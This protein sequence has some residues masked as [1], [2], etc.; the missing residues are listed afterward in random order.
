MKVASLLK[1]PTAVSGAL[2]DRYEYDAFGQPYSGDLSSAMNLGYTGKPYDTATG[3]Y[4]YGYRDY[5]PQMARFTTLDPIRDGNNWFA[6][7]NNDPVNWVDLWGLCADDVGITIWGTRTSIGQIPG[8]YGYV[9]QDDMWASIPLGLDTI[10]KQGCKVTGASQIISSI[11]GFS[12]S[13][14]EI[15]NLAAENGNLSQ[16]AIKNKIIANN[17]N[18]D[19]GNWEK[20]QLNEQKLNEIK[21][22]EVTT[23]ILGRADVG[24]DIGQHWV[25]ITDYSV[26]KKGIIT[27]SVSGTSKNDTMRIFTSGSNEDSKWIG[28]INR[29][30]TYTVK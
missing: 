7:V 17:V 9:Q 26:D 29:I 2:E 30:E 11:V 12:F 23:Y 24:G 1:S 6:Y 28:T 16:N 10:G 15:V 4:N 14:D 22:G 5:K 3:L 18:V 8:T 19:V 27:Y 25:V 20:E 13:P 21:N